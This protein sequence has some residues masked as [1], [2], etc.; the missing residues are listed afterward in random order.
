MTTTDIVRFLAVLF[1]GLALGPSAAH[2]LELPNK[3]GLSRDDYL[4][5]QQIYRGWNL[6]AVVVVGALAST[7]VLAVRVR[8]EHR[9]FRLAI[10]AFVCLVAAQAV[11]WLWTFPMN[12][13]TRN[14]T[15]LPQVW[16]PLRAQW[17][18]S[19]AFGALLNLAA[20][21]LLVLCLLAARP[22]ASQRPRG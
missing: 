10:A 16:E 8:W 6:L 11:F 13:A 22:A 20:L 3:I 12:Q 19:H 7:L 21:A 2:L 4:V 5:V 14:W 15:E 9:Q 17:E 1:V 18:Y